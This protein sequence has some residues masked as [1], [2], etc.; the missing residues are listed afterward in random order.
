MLQC[1]RTRAR[2][3]SAVAY[4]GG[5]EVRPW[6][7]SC[8]TL[9]VLRMRRSRSMQ[10]A[11]R[12]WGRRAWSLWAVRSNTRQLRFS[13]RPCPLSEERNSFARLQSRFGVRRV[14][15]V[16]DAGMISKKMIAAVEARG[17]FY[18]LGARLRRTKEVRDVVLS[19]DGSRSLAR[20]R[21]GPT[22]H[23]VHSWERGHLAGSRASCPREPGGRSAHRG[24][25]ARARRSPPH[26]A[27]CSCST[28][29]TP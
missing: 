16:A 8:S 19:E 25:E 3:S 29:R 27:S 11:T 7:V 22:R 5:T 23:V 14:C 28:S 17:W 15:L 13:S 10:K 1:P 4:S 6:T 20:L 2:T 21:L 12:R 9:P 24:L 26:R 18:I